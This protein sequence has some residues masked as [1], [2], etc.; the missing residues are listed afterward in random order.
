MQLDSMEAYKYKVYSRQAQTNRSAPVNY[1]LSAYTLKVFK[2][3]LHTNRISFALFGFLLG[4]I[5]N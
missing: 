2:G 4:R 5:I 1:K 3:V